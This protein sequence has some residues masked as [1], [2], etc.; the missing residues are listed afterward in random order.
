MKSVFLLLQ[1]AVSSYLL[2]TMTVWFLGQKLLSFWGE[3]IFAPKSK[4]HNS[5][6]E[7]VNMDR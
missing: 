1:F 6:I 3:I 5:V 2:L 4:Y 7:D